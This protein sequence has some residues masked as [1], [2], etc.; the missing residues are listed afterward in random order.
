MV[1]G[2]L[3]Y[4]F[5]L[6]ST[7]GTKTDGTNFSLDVS[8]IWN[9]LSDSACLSADQ[10]TAHSDS[11]GNLCNCNLCRGILQRH[12]VKKERPLPLGL[13]QGKGQYQRCDPPGLRSFL[14]GSGIN[15]RKDRDSNIQKDGMILWNRESAHSREARP[16]HQSASMIPSIKSGSAP[17]FKV[18]RVLLFIL[19]SSEA[20][21]R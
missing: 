2:D 16:P 20:S 7:P 12:S 18:L 6:L 15:F 4:S 19:A 9:G 11:G 5:R 3:I 13:Q 10:K 1:Y 17:I 14:D 21:S 8:H